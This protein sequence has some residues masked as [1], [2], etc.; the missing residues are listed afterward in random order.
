MLLTLCTLKT[1]KTYLF[2]FQILRWGATAHTTMTSSAT[3]DAAPT[4]PRG[5]FLPLERPTKKELREKLV[6][7]GIMRSAMGEGMKDMI[8]P[9]E[10]MIPT[11]ENLMMTKGKVTSLKIQASG[12]SLAKGRCLQFMKSPLL[13]SLWKSPPA[14]LPFKKLIF[15]RSSTGLHIKFIMP[16]LH[17]KAGFHTGV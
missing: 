10:M 2:L 17:F 13:P 16:R 6:R 7:G 15:K 3:E 12:P 11:N 14:L 9:R 1:S 4:I 5:I 8:F